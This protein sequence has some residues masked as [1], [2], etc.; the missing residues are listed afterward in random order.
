MILIKNSWKAAVECSTV[1]CCLQD[2][3]RS[4]YT[5]VFCKNVFVKFTGKHLCWSLFLRKLQVWRPES[6][7]KRDSN[8]VAV[9]WIL[10]NLQE[11]LWWR[12]SKTG[13]SVTFLTNLC[14]VAKVK[15]ISFSKT[16]RRYLMNDLFGKA[17]W[18][19]PAVFLK[20]SSQC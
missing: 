2:C 17:T 20:T 9:L 11:H 1:L 15:N 14:E 6:L 7:L 5:K 12:I 18:C 19:K 4:S 10:Q 16:L 8:T 3:C 13:C